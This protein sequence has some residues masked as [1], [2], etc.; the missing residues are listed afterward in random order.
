M[1]DFRRFR[2]TEFMFWVVKSIAERGNMLLKLI[3]W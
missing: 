3:M 1:R 2:G